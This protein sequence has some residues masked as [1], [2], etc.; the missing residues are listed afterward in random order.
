[1]NGFIYKIT[2]PKKKVYIGQSINVKK[3]FSCYKRLD[4][5]AQV[6][7][8]RSFIKY[9]IAN[10]L[11]E[12]IHECNVD[13]LNKIERYYQDLFSACSK[14]GLNCVLTAYK[15]RR[16]EISNET[17]IKLSEAAKKQNRQINRVVSLE[18]RLK[19]SVANTGKKRTDEQKNRLRNAVKNSGNYGLL[20]GKRKIIARNRVFSEETR[21]KMSLAKKGNK[22][23]RYN[24][25]IKRSDEV[26]SRMKMAQSVNSIMVKCV[27]NDIV[28]TSIRDCAKQLN[29]CK[30][31]L[32]RCFKRKKM[33]VK[34]Y[35]FELIITGQV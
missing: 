16:Y 27:N 2:S 4:C 18:T 12:I 17:R 25:G 5:K 33:T 32:S 9:G 26:K 30:D 11:F 3:R 7:L 14:S 1:M 23:G 8:Y 6:K 24:I 34:G 29:L 22:Y 21:N 19:I 10:H 35:Y 31:H 20:R 13:E 15:N 28:Y